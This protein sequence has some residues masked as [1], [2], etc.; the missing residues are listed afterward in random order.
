MEAEEGAGLPH[1]CLKID[2][3]IYNIIGDTN[4]MCIP[5]SL[6]GGGAGGACPPSSLLSPSVGLSPPSATAVS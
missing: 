6:G 3:T 5:G 4:I 2:V 1:Q